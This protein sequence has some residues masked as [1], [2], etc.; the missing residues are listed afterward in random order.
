MHHLET[1]IQAIPPAVFAAG[2]VMNANGVMPSPVDPTSNP[3]AS[4]ASST[5]TYPSGVPPPSLNTYPLMNPSTFFGPGKS[6]SRHSSP[7]GPSHGPGHAHAHGNGLGLGANGLHAMTDRLADET[8]RM[9]L[10][11]NYLYF[12]DEG[13]TRWQ[14]ETSGMPILDLLVERRKNVTKQEP[15]QPALAHNWANAQAQAINDWFPDRPQRRTETNP[16]VI[17]KLVTSFIE[18][19]L[20]D[21]LVVVQLSLVTR[22]INSST[23]VAWSSVISLP[24]T[25]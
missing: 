12:D 24:L 13:Y 18:S 5:H 8:A 14:G 1:L 11:P 6:S 16:E 15:D 25:I 4:F 22:L 9:S 20:M 7:V 10:S 19:D 2:G 23:L 17:W 3:H 21:R